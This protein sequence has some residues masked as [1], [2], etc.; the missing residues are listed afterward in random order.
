MKSVVLLSSGMDSTVNLYAAQKQGPVLLALTFDYG[1][2]AAAREIS[3]SQRL[4]QELGIRHQVVSLPFFSDLGKSSLVDKTI[5]LPAVAIDDLE[6]S[7]K[8]AQSVWVPNRNGI[9]LNIA[10]GF[11][12]SLEAEQ[13][14]P[15]FNKEEA[16]TFPDNSKEFMLE[17]TRALAFSTANKVRVQCYTVDL[18]KTQIVSLGQSLGVN[19]SQIWP[20]YQDLTNWCGQCE[21]CQRARRA[22][23]ANGVNIENFMA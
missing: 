20:C 21:S 15:G 1:Q 19:W 16:L 17:S 6:T 22:F 8:S 4:C 12:E 23:V 9:F 11:A 2:R 14:V 7:I 13:I 18:N 5:Q 10:A 3:Q